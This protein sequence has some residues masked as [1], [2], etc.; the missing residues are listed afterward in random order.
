MTEVDCTLKEAFNSTSITTTIPLHHSCRPV[1]HILGLLSKHFDVD[2]QEP[3]QLQRPEH[4]GRML[5]QRLR[6]S[7]PSRQEHEL[8]VGSLVLCLSLPCARL[9]C[10]QLHAANASPCP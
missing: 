10:A 8:E 1:T 3:Q 7:L 2:A 9:M 6:N 4:L 5:K